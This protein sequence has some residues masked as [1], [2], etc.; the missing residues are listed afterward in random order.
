MIY[1]LGLKS[2]YDVMY[3]EKR[4]LGEKMVKKG[5]DGIS[6]YPGGSVFR[7]REDAERAI[8]EYD[9]EGF[10]VYGIEA[11]WGID[12]K[13]EEDE[14]HHNLLWDRPIIKLDNLW[15]PG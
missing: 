1:T 3:E 8:R 6:G 10:G 2:S 14:P 5:A 11:E 7:T 4:R 15:L 9:L 12:T 13:P